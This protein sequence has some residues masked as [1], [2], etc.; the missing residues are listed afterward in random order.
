MLKCGCKMSNVGIVVLIR[1]VWM[2]WFGGGLLMECLKIW[3]R[4]C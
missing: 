2:R 3:M 1:L 4:M